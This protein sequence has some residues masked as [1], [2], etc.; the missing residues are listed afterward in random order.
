MLIDLRYHLIALVAVFLA[1][2]VGILVG[3][4]FIGGPSIKGL[5]DEFGKLR[6]E[7]R[8]QQQTIDNL[9]DLEKKR[10]EFENAVLPGLINGRLHNRRIAI[11][12]TGDYSEATQSAASILEKAGAKIVSITTLSSLESDVAKKRAARAVELITEETNIVD[13][14]DR[15]L[16][17]I[18]GTVVMGGYP[19]R[20]KLLESKG[21]LSGSGEY[22]R[23]VFYVV[24]V[25]GGKYKTGYMQAQH[26]N[27][28]LIDKLK[29][30]GVVAL[31]GVEPVGAVTSYIP[32]YHR[33]QVP[34]VDNV[35]QPMG[36]VAL[37]FAVAGETGNFGVKKTADSVVPAYLESGQW[38]YGYR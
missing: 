17:I 8:S 9:R 29:E 28:A 18:A 33:K 10:D 2:A 19:D 34:T 1:L 7:I 22:D 14:V 5:E 12:Q 4:S 38:R 35:D 6:V 20:V 30:L 23:R 16:G 26:A 13:P 11:I 27:L 21:L 15:L 37:V 32:T 36:Q 31:V 24:I 25:G 3:S